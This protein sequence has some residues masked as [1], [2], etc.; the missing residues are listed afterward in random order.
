MWFFKI[1]W[2][3][4]KLHRV[5][6]GAKIAFWHD[7]DDDDIDDGDDNDNDNDDDDNDDDNDN[8]NDNDNNTKKKSKTFLIFWVVAEMARFSNL[9]LRTMSKFR[10]I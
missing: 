7:D 3:I 9:S 5:K 8:D 6:V 10:K 2:W 1:E 4:S